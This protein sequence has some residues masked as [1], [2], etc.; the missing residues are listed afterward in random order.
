[1]EKIKLTT[2]GLPLDGRRVAP[3]DMDHATKILEMTERGYH[4]AARPQN[5][6]WSISFYMAKGTPEQPAFV[7]L[8]PGK[9]HSLQMR[10]YK[11]SDD[12]RLYDDQPDWIAKLCRL[13]HQAAPPHI[14]VYQEEQSDG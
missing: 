4:V 5:G 11:G 2:A 1:M 13:L 12:G 3:P 8:Q 7:N 14:Q 9:Y 6:I 10:P